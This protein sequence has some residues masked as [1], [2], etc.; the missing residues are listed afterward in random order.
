M[1]F[2]VNPPIGLPNY[3]RVAAIAVPFLGLGVGLLALYNRA[4]RVA[5][6][7]ATVTGRAYRPRRVDLG[8]WRYP[9]LALVAL[10]LLLVQQQR[11][12]LA[13]ALVARPKLLLLDEPLSNLDARL[14]EQMRD[15][16]RS[17]V[18]MLG[19]TALY[20]THDRLEALA[21]SHRIAVMAY[22]RIV[23]QGAPAE[24]YGRPCNRFVADF[25]GGANFLPVTVGD[26]EDGGAR[27]ALADGTVL[28]CRDAG[29]GAAR[30][31]RAVVLVR[32]EDVELDREP[33]TGAPDVLAAEV[34][35]VVFQG[36]F[37]EVRTRTPCGPLTFRVRPAQAPAPGDRV[38]VR[39]PPDACT[40][41]EDGSGDREEPGR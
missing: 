30:G 15:E 9:A 26:A 27:A 21:L 2:A 22:G 11:V 35:H 31:R 36:S 16:L 6:R 38:R 3:G 40:V 14:R 37:A 41:L 23:Q 28:H 12:A 18:A 34:E 33:A 24:I 4:L 1:F 19:I 5:E 29:R 39:I 7:Y 25:L 13:R 17:L 10:Y 20:V 32:P 8:R